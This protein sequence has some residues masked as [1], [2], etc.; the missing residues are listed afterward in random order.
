MTPDQRTNLRVKVFISCTFGPN[1]DTPRSAT[2]TSISVFGCFVKTKGWATKG[3]K[4]YVRLWLPEG[5]WL[6]LQGTVIYHMERVG[7]G[8]TFDEIDLEDKA[9]IKELVSQAKR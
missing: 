6:P 2:V 4:M 7:F 3:Q 1:P 5:Q 9:K 8:L